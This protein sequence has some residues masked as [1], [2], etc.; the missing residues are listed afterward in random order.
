MCIR[1]SYL[2]IARQFIERLRNRGF[3]LPIIQDALRQVR[4]N[5]R[6]KMLLP[7]EKD[8]HQR[9]SNKLVFVTKFDPVTEASN[10]KKILDVNELLPNCEVTVAYKRNKNL[11]EALRQSNRRNR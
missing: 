1:D 3:P 2:S 4:Y 8:Q 7:K 11:R 6:D 9:T 10:W 5:Q